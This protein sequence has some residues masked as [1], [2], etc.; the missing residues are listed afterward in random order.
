MQYSEESFF[1][2]ADISS[3]S[4]ICEVIKQ[5]FVRDNNLKT[6]YY[7][8]KPL[9]NYSKA[10]EGRQASVCCYGDVR[11]MFNSFGQYLIS[12]HF[13]KVTQTI[14]NKYALQST[15]TEFLS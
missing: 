3:E 8:I 1:S 6:R 7:V 13:C 11:R 15:Q 12:W 10:L 4:K 14:L 2:F 9:I 5:R